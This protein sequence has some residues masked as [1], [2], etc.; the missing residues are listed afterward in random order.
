MDGYHGPYHPPV[1]QYPMNPATYFVAPPHSGMATA[2]MVFGIIGICGGF[3]FLG[4]PCFM[5]VLLGHI[6]MSETKNGKATGRSQA[7]TG[8]ILG[9]L[10]VLPVAIWISIMAFVHFANAMGIGA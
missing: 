9:Y 6:G 2:S 1:Q 4:I 3:L 10:V 5:A 8:L 7:V